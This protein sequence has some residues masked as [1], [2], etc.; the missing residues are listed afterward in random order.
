MFKRG[1]FLVLAI[2][3]VVFATSFA[4]QMAWYNKLPSKYDPGIALM[5]AFRQSEKP[6][7]IEFYSDDCSACQQLTPLLHQQYKAHFDKD[8]TL[9]MVDVYAPQNAQ[10]AQLFGVDT[11]PAVFIFDA[12]HMK[13][14]AIDITTIQ[15]EN[16]LT[17]AVIQGLATV[18]QRTETAQKVL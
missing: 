10:A 18:K 2:V 16:D 3:A 4:T 11:I 15:S 17:Q 6:L 8:L 14:V 9:V 7:L 12:K 5:T 13:K 1:L